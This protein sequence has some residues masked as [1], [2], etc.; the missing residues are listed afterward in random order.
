MTASDMFMDI[1]NFH[2]NR[3]LGLDELVYNFCN[4]TSSY[5]FNNPNEKNY[6]PCNIVKYNTDSNSIIELQFA[7]AGL[8]KKDIKI[9]TEK[10][11][12]TISYNPDEIEK[13]SESKEDEIIPKKY[14]KLFKDL[15]NASYC[16][17]KHGISQRK[18]QVSFLLTD[19][20]Q[21]HSCEMK[22]GILTIILNQ[23]IPEEKNVKYFT[24][25]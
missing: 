9:S 2:K 11:I 4:A 16:C 14:E 15:K 20:Y 8:S 7:L 18:F 23:E 24:I 12:L 1:L 13:S 5:D 21:V 17:I 25:K 3:F 19:F 22:N 10:N 6:P